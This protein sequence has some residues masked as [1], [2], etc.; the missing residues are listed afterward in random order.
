MPCLLPVITMAEGPELSEFDFVSVTRGNRVARP[1]TTPKKLVASVLWKYAA[2]S[3]GVEV[4]GFIL[5]PALSMRKLIVENL[6]L[7]VRS[8][9]TCVHAD[10][11]DTSRV[12]VRIWGEVFVLGVLG[13][14]A[15]N[16]VLAFSRLS[17][18]M[19]ARATCIPCRRQCWANAKPT[20]DAEPVMNASVPGRNTDVDGDAIAV[21]VVP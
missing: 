2:S 20:P 4:L 15:C 3:H 19:S 12:Y 17:L 13:V 10:K 18:L 6:L 16:A 7:V 21:V 8:D 11:S 9:L 1:W 14:I 5:I